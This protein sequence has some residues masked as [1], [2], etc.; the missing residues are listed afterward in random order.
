MRRFIPLKAN[1][2]KTDEPACGR[3]P[4]IA[5][6][7]LRESMNAARCAIRDGPAR[8]QKLRDGPVAIEPKDV[9]G[10]RKK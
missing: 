3:Q 2:V 10:S 4:Q 6:G 1:A 8:M 5:I 7:C 9:M